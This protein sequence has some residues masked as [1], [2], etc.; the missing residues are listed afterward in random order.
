M[1]YRN[2][3]L[4]TTNNFFRIDIRYGRRKYPRHSNSS[5]HQETHQVQHLFYSSLNNAAYKHAGLGRKFVNYE[6]PS[7]E[8]LFLHWKFVYFCA[9]QSKN[10]YIYRPTLTIV[11]VETTST[12][13]NLRCVTL[14][15]T[16]RWVCYPKSEKP[17]DLNHINTTLLYSF[18]THFTYKSFTRT[19]HVYSHDC[20]TDP[21]TTTQLV[22][23]CFQLDRMLHSL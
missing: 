6:S 16:A 20:V 18:T 3:C 13:T 21:T 12:K 2:V 17:S 8:H 19:A 14:I 7:N 15:L 1:A 9:T 10:M 22:Q 4:K 23:F 11:N 5:S